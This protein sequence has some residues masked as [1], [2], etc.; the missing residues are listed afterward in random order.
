MSLIGQGE[1]MAITSSIVFGFTQILVRQGIQN[2]SPVAAAL[3]MNSMVSVGG[4]CIAIVSGTLINS[5]LPP[6]LWYL[7]I[8]ITGP[9]IARVMYYIGISRMGV[10]RTAGISS[11]TPIWGV[12]FAA[13]FLGESPN[14]QIILGTLAVVFGVGVLSLQNDDS[15]S[16]KNWFQTAIFFALIASIAYA[17]PPILVKF[18]YKY[19]STPAVGMFFSFAMGNI[20]LLSWKKVLPE[21]GLIKSNKK[22]LL[23]L[24][25]AGF[26]GITS[27]WFLW[28]AFSIADISTTL[29]L[30]RTAPIWVVI[31]SRIFLGKTEIINAKIWGGT[32]L[33]VLG[34]IAI[35]VS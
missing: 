27:S 22:G 28:N 21:K 35:V 31:F 1:L 26:G 34:G 8:G 5:T 7:V 16:F 29:P 9:G 6:I 23:I 25:I 19:Q 33:V 11:A 2:A 10:S 12:I 18:A 32:V 13:I 14:T 20:V 3:I 30:S 15:K 17:I 4:L 24:I